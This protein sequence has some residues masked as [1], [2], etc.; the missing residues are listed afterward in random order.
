M[1]TIGNKLEQARKKLGTSIEEAAVATK[2]RGEFLRYFEGDQFD[3]DLPDI[4]KNGFLRIYSRYLKLDTEKIVADYNSYR[5]GNQQVEPMPQLDIKHSYGRMDLPAKEKGEAFLDDYDDDVVPASSGPG[6]Q[7]DKAL[8]LKIGVGVA[9]AIIVALL[10]IWVIGALTTS[11]DQDS[12]RAEI[13]ETVT[14]GE[15]IILQAKGDVRVEIRDVSTNELLFSESLS[16][17]AEKPFTLPGRVWIQTNT[18][19]NLVIVADGEEFVVE[20][21]GPGRFKFPGQ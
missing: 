10:F 15:Q 2:I 16:K 19:E 1:Q 4:Y 5:L 17:G 9:A 6:F 14:A 12:S 3:F 21:P 20:T 18:L 8:L 7:V 11:S 13:V